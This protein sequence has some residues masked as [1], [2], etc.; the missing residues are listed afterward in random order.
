MGPE[1]W[2]RP[3]CGEAKQIQA[4]I[5]ERIRE[6]MPSSAST[7]PLGLGTD[8]RQSEGNFY[9]KQDGPRAP[10]NGP[11]IKAAERFVRI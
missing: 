7:C 6:N 1:G 3:I 10:G 11:F 8:A 4:T 5:L 9:S 2:A